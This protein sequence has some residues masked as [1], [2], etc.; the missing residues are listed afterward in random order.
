M[1]I[2]LFFFQLVSSWVRG[3]GSPEKVT[4]P[5]S[6]LEKMAMTGKMPEKEKQD[7]DDDQYFSLRNPRG[8]LVIDKSSSKHYKVSDINGSLQA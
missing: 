8:I 7:D 6:F 5:D 3:R 4:R 1:L 2:T